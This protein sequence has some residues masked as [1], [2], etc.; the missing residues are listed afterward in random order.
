M[1]HPRLGTV[2]ES[3]WILKQD[4]ILSLKM[5]STHWVGKTENKKSNE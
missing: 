5:L 4:R 2:G 1:Q 3:V